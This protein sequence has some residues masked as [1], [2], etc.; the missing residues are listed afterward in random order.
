VSCGLSG[1]FTEDVVLAVSK[2]SFVAGDVVKDETE[3][4]SLD[5]SRGSFVVFKEGVVED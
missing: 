2:G 4:G 5:G 1:T 3:D